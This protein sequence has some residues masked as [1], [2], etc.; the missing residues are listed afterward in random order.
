MFAQSA[1]DLFRGKADIEVGL[2][3]TVNERFILHDSLGFEPGDEDNYQT[4][5]NFIKGRQG[6]PLKDQLHAVW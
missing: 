4:V 6:G 1:S 3:S 5:E 2:E